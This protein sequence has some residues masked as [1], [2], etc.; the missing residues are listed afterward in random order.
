MKA[1]TRYV[2]KITQSLFLIAITVASLPQAYADNLSFITI[3][4]A[5]WA[6]HN[7]ESGN[8][9]GAFIEIVKE[10]GNRLKKEI[11]VSVIPFAR[12]DRELQSG[13]HDCTILVPRP[14]ELVIKG[15]VVSFHPIGFIARKNVLIEKYDDIKNLKLSVIRGGSLTPEFDNDDTLHKEYDTDYLIGLRKVARG[16]LDAIVGAIPTLLFLAEQEGLE[17]EFSDPFQVLEIPL[18]FQCSKESKNLAMMPAMNKIL[19]E[20]KRDGTLEK[21]R[22]KYY[23]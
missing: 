5:P 17:K 6:S 3:D 11:K 9:E 20:I 2:S 10:L 21:I 7:T 14:D 13:E 8:N 1:A 18:V 16:R 19:N 23:F 15:D 22:S 12:I 4:V